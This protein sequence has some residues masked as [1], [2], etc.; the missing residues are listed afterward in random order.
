MDLTLSGEHYFARL[1]VA[2]HEFEKLFSLQSIQGNAP[3]G[4]WMALDP[5]NN[6]LYLRDVGFFE[7]FALDVDLP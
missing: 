2:N 7:I 5:D 1:R 6:P 4:Q 3:L